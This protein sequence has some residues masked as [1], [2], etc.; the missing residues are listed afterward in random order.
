M[1]EKN[2][3]GIKHVAHEHL[4]ILNETYVAKKGFHA[5]HG[6]LK[7]IDSC[8]SSVY[9]CSNSTSCPTSTDASGVVHICIRFLLHKTCAELPLKIVDPTNQKQ[10]LVFHK[11]PRVTT[12]RLFSLIVHCKL[13]FRSWFGFCYN[14]S[15]D[16]SYICLMCAII[17]VEQSKEDPIFEHPGHSHPL[18]SI[19]QPSSFKCCACKV[20]DTNILDSSY[21]CTKCQFWI[22]KSCG[23]APHSSQ[24]QFHK[25]ALILSFSLP[26]VYH[27]FPQFCRICSERLYTLDWLYCCYSCRYFTHFQ[28]ARSSPMLSSSENETYPNLVHLPAAD[29]LSHNLLLEQ[30]IKDTVTLSHSS[31]GNIISSATNYIKHWSH[32]HDLK[33][34]TTSELFDKKNDDDILLLCDGCVKPIQTF[35]SLFYACVPCKYV[36]HKFC[37]EFPQ[38]IEHHLW[39][40]KKLFSNKFIEPFQLFMCEGCGFYCNG[41]F[42]IDNLEVTASDSVKFS[43]IHIGCVSLPKVIKHEAHCHQLDQVLDNTI[44]DCNASI[45]AIGVQIKY[46]CK[47]CKFD[48]CGKCITKARTCKN[49]WDPHP[50]DWIYDTGMVNDHEHDYDCEFC[51]KEIDTNKWFYHCS[52]CDLSFH[53][54][55]VENLS[56]LYYKDVKFGATDIKIK[57]QVHPHALTFV[58]NKKVRRCRNCDGESFGIPVLQCTPCKSTIFCY[59]KR[60][61]GW[62]YPD[63]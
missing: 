50:L 43:C 51:P 61:L 19:E 39:P 4:L 12:D 2:D 45:H 5:C 9:S 46:R 57:D 6:C 52:K 30:F 24:F 11:L 58:L 63:S 17:H 27:K 49:R 38:E 26:Q 3:I 53:T 31:N 47:K 29:E 34:I 18:A 10:F 55:C 35:D 44:N 37:A 33:L 7:R 8:K 28:C 32:K 42:F 36:L 41:I 23:D 40:G 14:S 13:C 22:H 25:H 54:Y 1:E 15:S 20:N 48:I 21:R 16:Y 62:C 56:H 59:R 60:G